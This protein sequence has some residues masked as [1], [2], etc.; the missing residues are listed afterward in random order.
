[1][2]DGRICAKEDLLVD[3]AEDLRRN[4]STLQYKN[5]LQLTYASHCGDCET[6]CGLSEAG[7][8]VRA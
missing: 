7:V 8:V 4:I 6:A 2:F 5:M 3:V 1:M